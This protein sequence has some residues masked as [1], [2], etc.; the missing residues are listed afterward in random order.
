VPYDEPEPDDPHVLVGVALPAS[1]SST[2]ERAAA[3]ADEFA[4]MG[5]GR[6]RLLRIFASP[7]YAGARTALEL[8]G[9]EEIERIVDES[10]RVLGTRR[11]SVQDAPESAE[12]TPRR[13]VTADER[14]GNERP[15]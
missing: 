5:F 4:Q 2:R 10:L 1:V 8:L 7:F 9:A 15:A 14:S 13:R 6:D 12:D 11:L 3:F